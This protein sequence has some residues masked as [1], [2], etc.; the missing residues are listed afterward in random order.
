MIKRLVKI[1]V[2]ILLALILIVSVLV[3]ST[4]IALS[5]E[6]G[7]QVLYDYTFRTL[8]NTLNTRLAVKEIKADIIRGRIMLH[9]FEL[10]DQAGVKMLKVDSVGAQI[11]I[12]KIFD[13]EITIR[14]LYMKG[15]SM[16]LYKNRPDSAA[17]YQ[18]VLDA[19]KS[20]SAK[21]KKKKAKEKK[22]KEPFFHLS[23]DM[24]A[25]TIERTN[26][27]WDILSAPRKGKDTLDVNHL[28]IR[29]L[30]FIL[31]GNIQREYFVNV[32]LKDFHVAE[33]NSGAV[34]TLQKASY[35]THK[36]KDVDIS[37]EGLRFR[38]QD[39]RVKMNTLSVQQ[40]H[41]HF[42]FTKPLT[43]KVDS[44]FFQNDNHKPRKN[45]KKPNR[46]WFDP[47]HLNA[48]ASLEATVNYLSKDSMY[49][50]V[51]HIN[52]VD[53]ASGLDVRHL[54]T[55]VT[56]SGEKI[57]LTNIFIGLMRTRIRINKVDMRGT[58]I[59]DFP[60]E[61]KVYLQDI[62]KP[63]APILGNFTTP[64]D[65]KLVVG[66]DIDRY[67][68]K[69]IRIT[70]SD[71]RLL[72]TGEGDLCDVTKKR[73]LTL[74]F[75]DLFMNASGGIKEQIVN[76]FS[77]KV[78]LKMQREM[79]ALGDVRYK[80]KVGIFFRRQDIS[81]TL[82]TRYGDVDF[83]FTLDGNTRH[84]SGTLNTDTLNLGAIFNIKNLGVSRMNAMYD[85]DITSKRKA[86]LLGLKPK[87]RLPVGMLNAYVGSGRYGS[88]RVKNLK[89]EMVSD[90]AV[91]QGHI[92][93]PQSLVNIDV[94]FSYTQTDTEQG[95]RIHPKFQFTD[96][97]RKFFGLSPKKEKE[98]KTDKKAKDA[99]DAKDAKKD[100]ESKE[101]KKSKKDKKTKETKNT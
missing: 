96:K 90:G 20:K 75:W 60:M 38:Y 55:F 50:H 3:G 14:G 67:L 61:A 19:L 34:F 82:F 78:R 43:L 39:K 45:F 16:Y 49:A 28:D 1:L 53:M 81:G 98:A 68:F 94:D 31:K 58:T 93:L 64:L 85:F 101:T 32:L 84:M 54:S 97:V 29:N 37:F 8:Q 51:T 46:G 48:V 36:Q 40:H 21:E 76:H 4:M 95:L 25:L 74:H 88:L 63:F 27:K 100:T 77:K 41:G 72:I 80:G 17:N 52:A 57:T 24:A 5:T 59:D 11:G 87:G 13:R 69:K 7:Q 23:T 92:D 62:A 30:S 2:R 71:E 6:W 22:K 15:A 44:I 9:G 42:D 56:R 73:D 12:N 26:F 33:K 86:K 66:G 79:K 99:K 65:L 35:L 89:A 83:A 18:F 47:G 91:A 10:D 70:T